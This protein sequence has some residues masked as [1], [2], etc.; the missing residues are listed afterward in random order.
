MDMYELE[1][2]A[3]SHVRE[4]L[5]RPMPESGNDLGCEGDF[6]PWDIFPSIY[7]SYSSEF[8][9]CAIEVLCDLRDL[10]CRRIDLAAEIIRE[11]L[12]VADLCEYG[13]SPRTC[14]P[15]HEFAALLPSLIEKWRAYAALAWDEE[16]TTS[17]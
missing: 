4:I 1:E 5:A 17:K 9:K 2:R 12:C 7:G 11:M 15:S 13:T 6:D 16:V 8:D 3:A 10:E 14:F